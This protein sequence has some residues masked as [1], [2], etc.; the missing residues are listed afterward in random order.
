MYTAGRKATKQNDSFCTLSNFQQD[1]IEKTSSSSCMSYTVFFSFFLVQ[2]SIRSG[3]I[4]GHVLTGGIC[5]STS[6]A[7]RRRTCAAWLFT[8]MENSIK[9]STKL[10]ILEIGKDPNWKPNAAVLPVQMKEI[11]QNVLPKG[12]T[13]QLQRNKYKHNPV[14]GRI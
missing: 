7:R 10:T 11:Q 8:S 3:S 6:N 5:T 9:T 2:V 1:E 14:E 13:Q 4:V 12:N